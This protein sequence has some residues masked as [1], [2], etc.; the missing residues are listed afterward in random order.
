MSRSGP[1]MTEGSGFIS[2]GSEG[3]GGPEVQVSFDGKAEQR[4]TLM[5]AGPSRAFGGASHVTWRGA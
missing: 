4:N 2:I 5:G 1:D 3:F